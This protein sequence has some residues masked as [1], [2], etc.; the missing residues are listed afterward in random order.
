MKRG[1]TQQEAMAYVGVKRR[2]G[3]AVVVGFGDRRNDVAPERLPHD[4]PP[5]SDAPIMHQLP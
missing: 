2:T 4:P 1:L 5:Q 3:H